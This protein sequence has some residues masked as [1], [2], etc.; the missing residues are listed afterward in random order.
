MGKREEGRLGGKGLGRVEEKDGGWR[1]EHSTWAGGEAGDEGTL[2]IPLSGNTI[3]R[4]FEILKTVVD[5]LK[6]PSDKS[7]MTSV[8]RSLHKIICCRQQFVVPVYCDL[9]AILKC[10]HAHLT[11]MLWFY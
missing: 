2:H 8:S 6:R 10:L 1:K 4:F 9:L 7:V 5:Y 11:G 3:S